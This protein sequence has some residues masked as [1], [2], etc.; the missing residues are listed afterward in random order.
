MNCLQGMNHFYAI[1]QTRFILLNYLF[2]KNKLFH[3][4]FR[5]ITAAQYHN[6]LKHNKLK[7][8]KIGAD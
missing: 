3:R 4:T 7:H 5:S 8:D 2:T 1:K 6:K